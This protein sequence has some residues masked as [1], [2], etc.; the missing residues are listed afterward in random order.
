MTKTTTSSHLHQ[1]TINTSLLAAPKTPFSLW[2]LSSPWTNLLK[3]RFSP[4]Y[5][6]SGLLL[7][8]SK[9]PSF[10]K[11]LS[12]ASGRL[13]SL[14]PNAHKKLTSASS[15]F[16]RQGRAK[17]LKVSHTPSFSHLDALHSALIWKPTS[18]VRKS[19]VPL[20]GA[21]MTGLSYF[22]KKYFSDH[23][24]AI[25]NRESSTSKPTSFFN[26][27]R[28]SSSLRRSTRLHLFGLYLRLSS[29]ASTPR[30][31]FSKIQTRIST[32]KFTV[33]KKPY[34]FLGLK[35]SPSGLR[36]SA[37]NALWKL[38]KV[39][40]TLQLKLRLGENSSA[41]RT[42]S[43]GISGSSSRYKQLLKRTWRRWLNKKFSTTKLNW[44]SRVKRLNKSFRSHSLLRA[45]PTFTRPPFSI[46]PRKVFLLAPGNSNNGWITDNLNVTSITKVHKASRSRLRKLRNLKRNKLVA[47]RR[48]RTLNSNSYL[49]PTKC[50]STHW[51]KLSLLRSNR[52]KPYLISNPKESAAV[53]LV[54][55]YSPKLA[56]KV[57]HLP[58]LLWGN[59][60]PCKLAIGNR[61]PLRFGSTKFVSSVRSLKTLLQY[62]PSKRSTRIPNPRKHSLLQARN[63]VLV[64]AKSHSATLLCR[65]S[66]VKKLQL[67]NSRVNP[68]GLETSTTPVS[69][70]AHLA[71]YVLCSVS[72][73]PNYP[74]GIPNTKFKVAA[75]FVR[76]VRP[77]LS[78]VSPRT[79][80]LK[81]LYSFSF[82]SSPFS[83]LTHLL[84]STARTSDIIKATQS[85]VKYFKHL[86]FPDTD[87]VKAS[88]FRRLN[89]QK[90]LFQARTRMTSVH[91]S[92]TPANSRLSTQTHPY[93]E[94][95]SSSSELN[96]GH[97]PHPV[98]TFGG[99]RWMYHT[100][101]T[102]V[103]RGR[104]GPVTPRIRRIRFKPGYGRIW[105]TARKSI[106]DILNM[107]VRYQYRL[108]PK[109]QKRYF[110]ARRS[111]LSHLSLTMG[112]ALMTSRLIF[113]HHTLKELL[114]SNNVYLN[115]IMCSN[116]STRLFVNDFV[117]LVVNLKFY[118]VLRWIKTW[119]VQRR[120]K[121]SRVFYRKI[122][123]MNYRK[124]NKT[125]KLSKNLPQW[126]FDLQYSQGDVPKYFEVDYFSLSI[127]VIH[128]QITSERWLPTKSNLYNPL[129]LNMYNWK[130]IT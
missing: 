17:A 31:S 107:P 44:T 68:H 16:L 26:K 25:V 27:A 48:P 86:V 93:M 113:D 9:S 52:V 80:Q 105:R 33:R 111:R 24:S 76:L 43:R 22:S 59:A 1:C 21:P 40:K 35:R 116:S 125:P 55:R 65:F 12:P 11:L 7:G 101:N 79:L 64:S 36:P 129:T 13:F 38:F 54:V 99:A 95:V 58:S 50:A 103:K 56:S 47:Y 37:N 3:Y 77:H 127:F 94:S 119:S 128:D 85:S 5:V 74:I 88:I 10:R 120:F 41:K 49:K 6:S 96:I 45:T 62:A 121:A 2:L 14:R 109:L 112:F 63:R 69:L 104:V 39:S 72:T 70:H 100:I 82:V 124:F 89:R 53:R 90:M 78:P 110:I 18:L 123:P 28:G 87:H 46:L 75:N 81:P 114:L 118:V 29:T 66:S 32:R 20:L 34:M 130:Y 122:K 102:F 91:Y 67:A 98:G 84:A 126:F 57:N 73:N 92:S 23:F 71:G 117:Q 42:A 97:V 106:K 8:S 19:Y 4:S 30:T 108:T 83:F 51:R 60:K 115:S 15:F 61:L